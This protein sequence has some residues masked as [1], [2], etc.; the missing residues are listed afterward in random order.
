MWPCHYDLGKCLTSLILICHIDKLKIVKLK[1]WMWYK[2]IN[3]KTSTCWC[4]F[5]SWCIQKQVLQAWRGHQRHYLE[6]TTVECFKYCS[7]CKQSAEFSVIQDL[8]VLIKDRGLTLSS[9]HGHFMPWVFAK[10][11]SASI[12]TW[13]RRACKTRSVC[14][15]Q[16]LKPAPRRLPTLR[17]PPAQSPLCFRP[18]NYHFEHNIFESYFALFGCSGAHKWPQLWE[19][20]A[21]EE[22]EV[23]YR[24]T[25]VLDCRLSLDKASRKRQAFQEHINF[26]NFRKVMQSG[27]LV[28]KALIP[29]I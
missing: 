1:K 8:I 20:K 17:V 26:E 15:G 14:G 9:A 29:L 4:D 6:I 3:P 5:S 19:I 27:L 13:L 25:L 12:Q 2:F 21:N 22:K 7:E 11:G 23:F 24:E 28:G 18:F 10:R 16:A